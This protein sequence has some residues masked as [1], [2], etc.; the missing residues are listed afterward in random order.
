MQRRLFTLAAVGLVMAVPVLAKGKKDITLPPYILQAHTVAVVIDNGAAIDPQDP[1]GNQVAQR[2]VEAAL[3][4]WGRFKPMVGP[5]GADLIIVIRKGVHPMADSTV[6]DPRQNSRPGMSTPTDNG[7]GVGAQAGRAPN[8][9][10]SPETPGQRPLQSASPQ[11]QTQ[12][13]GVEDSFSVYDGSL[14]RPMDNAPG[15]RYMGDDGLHPHNVPAVDAFKKAVAAADKAAAA[16][17]KQ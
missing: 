5:Q 2:D 15:W 13:G 3:M 1:R 14:A 17:P 16:A 8:L 7:M 6:T 4:S 11:T 12:I 10:G 9:G